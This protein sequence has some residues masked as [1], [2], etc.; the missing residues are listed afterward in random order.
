MKCLYIT[1]ILLLSTAAQA[2]NCDDLNST[3][4]KEIES[5]LSSLDKSSLQRELYKLG[6]CKNKVALPA[7][8]KYV[9]DVRIGHHALHKGMSIGYIAKGS[10]K[11]ISGE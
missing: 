2:M 6:G 3:S 7:L 10:I 1:S 4:S 9:D 8:Q 5:F 11:R